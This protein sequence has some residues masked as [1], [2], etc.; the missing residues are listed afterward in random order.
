[1]NERANR[2]YGTIRSALL[3]HSSDVSTDLDIVLAMVDGFGWNDQTLQYTVYI[4]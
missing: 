2:E 3:A 1:M 4:V